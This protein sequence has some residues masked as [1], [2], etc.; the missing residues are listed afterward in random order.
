MTQGMEMNVMTVS[1]QL[2]SNMNTSTMAACV[3]ERSAICAAAA[4]RQRARR[5]PRARRHP[6]R[7]APGRP[8]GRPAAGGRRARCRQHE[9][10]SSAYH[11]L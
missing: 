7:P 9:P 5:R 2:A 4:R 1:R 6:R 10:A 3:S 11:P 8:G